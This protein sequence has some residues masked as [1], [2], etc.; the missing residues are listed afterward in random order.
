LNAIPPSGT[1]NA[2]FKLVPLEQIIQTARLGSNGSSAG[3]P[4]ARAPAGSQAA[5]SASADAS[6]A[7]N[8]PGR[9]FGGMY[10]IDSSE[11]PKVM[12]EFEGTAGWGGAVSASTASPIPLSA[13]RLLAP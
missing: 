7:A 6:M 13:F 12:L 3:A 9:S 8:R 5:V 10:I 4:A 11:R 1:A 2:N